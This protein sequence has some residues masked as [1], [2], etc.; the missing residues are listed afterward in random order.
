MKNL[1]NSKE[2]DIIYRRLFE[3]TATAVI[4]IDD[5][6]RL[7][8]ANHAFSELVET[9]I[10]TL[11]N[12][13]FFKFFPSASIEKFK[14]YHCACIKKNKRSQNDLFQYLTATGKVGVASI[15]FAY[16]NDLKKTIVTMIDILDLNIVDSNLLKAKA[17]LIRA[18]KIGQI[19]HWSYQV[20]D[21]EIHWSDQL[22]VNFG[23]SKTT[24]PMT[25]EK[26]MSWIHPEDRSL[27]D[28]YFEK[29]L[30]VSPAT[31]NNLGT[32]QYRVITSTQEERWLKT[33]LEVEFDE[34]EH[35]IIFH[36]TVQNITK[37]KEKSIAL[38]E[39]KNR[40]EIIT[41]HA[42]VFIAQCDLNQHY[43]YVNKNYAKLFKRT[44]EEIIGKR[45]SDVLDTETYQVALPHI[46]KALSG[47]QTSY[48]LTLQHNSDTHTYAVVYEPELNDKDEPIGFIAAITNITERE[49]AEHQRR[50][51]AT[52]FKSQSGMMVTNARNE[53]IQVNPAFTEITGYK[54][55][56][57]YGKNPG[58]LAS[59]VHNDSFYSNI[60]SSINTTNKWVGEIWNKHANDE[61]YPVNM[62]I[63][64]VKDAN[65]T[66]A[67]YVATFTD[68]SETL[69]D[70]QK[71]E[72]LAFYDSL[73]ALPNRRL[74]LE[75][76]HQALAKSRRSKQEGA[77]LFIDLDDFKSI[78]DTLGHE[79]GDIFLQQVAKRLVSCVRE[80][81]NVIRFG[82][83]EFVVMLEDLGDNE[84]TAA[85]ATNNIADKIHR[86]LSEPYQINKNELHITAS[87]GA[88]LFEDQ[89]SHVLLKQADIAMYQAKKSG[90]NTTKFYDQAM[91][92]EIN[93]RV[94]LQKDLRAAVNKSQFELYYQVQVD[95]DAKPIG[96]EALLRWHHP[97][98]GLLLPNQ[99][100][101]VCEETGIIVPLGLLVL[102][103]AIKQIKAWENEPLTKH[104]V[105]SINVSSRQFHQS[106]FSSQVRSLIALYDIQP[107]K[108]KLELTESALLKNIDE[109]I[110]TMI[111]LKNSGIQFYLDDFG[112][113]YSSLQYLK[114]LPLFQLKIDQSFVR[115]ITTSSDDAVIVKT[116]IAMA[117]GFELET[118]AE[119]VEHEAELK[120]LTEMK[121]THF[122]GF[123][124]GKPLP[125]AEFESALIGGKL[126]A[127]LAE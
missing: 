123:L 86:V 61:I 70:A 91:Q 113:G 4:L 11:T 8:L 75:R 104:L 1:V 106:D 31:M 85:S 38:N 95:I 22:F 29:M 126:S 96:A 6:G 109:T 116:I 97:E 39:T 52:V 55:A 114:K 77:L 9:P 51:A 110:S 30:S 67:N 34:Q 118:I 41:N 35:P 62:V 121:C 43:R 120:L 13:S 101:P 92:I 65:D 111:D 3:S 107:S 83:D 20:S 10:E 16:I 28:Q 79:V 127:K 99:F 12:S 46:N 66:I 89:E 63:T 90:R 18:Q 74:L 105:V 40:L 15:N 87:I 5:D 124:F 44:P 7:F 50:I 17:D 115:D 103:M 56:D 98:K 60:W 45:I 122:Q 24:E 117:K 53:I 68:M 72:Y 42:P 58:V 2:A 125:I 108:L 37:S 49:V 57:V 33:S 14:R 48:D 73:T 78:N 76:L 84:F 54:E 88:T 64:A 71:I 19:G 47:R 81:D 93:K 102:E 27:H 25:Y 59:G 94:S 32:L 21:G 26:L 23:Q 82:G 36:G 100:I 119:G 80:K 69:A 112:T